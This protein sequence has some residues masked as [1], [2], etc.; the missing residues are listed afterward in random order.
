MILNMRLFVFFWLGVGKKM[1]DKPMHTIGL[2]EFLLGYDAEVHLA[3]FA[4]LIA[5]TR[6]HALT[7]KREISC[8]NRKTGIVNLLPIYFGGAVDNLAELRPV[9]RN[10]VEF[11]HQCYQH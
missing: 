10:D 2:N 9:F 1:R 6:R 11:F 4:I 8:E 7:G 3:P 5:K